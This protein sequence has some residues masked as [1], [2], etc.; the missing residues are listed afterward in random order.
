MGVCS[1]IMSFFLGFFGEFCVDMRGEC[2]GYVCLLGVLAFRFR[3]L[4]VFGGRVG[5]GVPLEVDWE[6][7]LRL[8]RVRLW[9]WGEVR[10]LMT[11]LCTV[12]SS[13][14][15]RMYFRWDL[16]SASACCWVCVRVGMHPWYMVARLMRSMCMP[17]VPPSVCR[18]VLC[19]WMSGV[20]FCRSGG[21]ICSPE[22]H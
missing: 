6:C 10:R 22:H 2:W 1:V 13:S 16:D 8:A 12:M 7:V 17:H 14:P 9:G 18:G 19:V 3:I 11:R 20:A 21:V 5:S 15:V 4:C